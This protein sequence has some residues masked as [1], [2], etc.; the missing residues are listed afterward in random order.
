[1]TSNQQIQS[2][3]KNNQEE[4]NLKKTVYSYTKHWKWFAFSGAICLVAAFFYLRY[5]TPEFNSYAKIMFV[6]D[7]NSS[8][9]AG[10]EVLKDL[11]RFS[12]T[13][14]KKTEDE[15]EAL[16]SRILM[17][18]VVKKLA[19]NIQYSTQ[20]RIHETQLYPNSPIKIIFTA[21]D[22]VVDNSKFSFIINITSNTTFNFKENTKDKESDFKEFAFGKNILTPLGNII[23]TPNTNEV[24]NLI[25]QTITVK[26][27]PVKEVAEYYRNK[28]EIRQVAELSKVVELSLNDAVLER[29]KQ[30]LNTLIDEY[31]RITIEEKNQRAISVA[32]FINERIDL[33]SM[34]L[35]KADDKVEHFKTGNRLTDITS[36]AQLYLNSSSEA[37]QEINSVRSQLSQINYM[38]N[39]VED[40][41]TAFEQIPSNAG[42]SDGSINNITTKYNDLL[43]E[44]NTLLKGST[45]QKNPIIVNLDQQLLGLKQSLVQSLENS[46]KTAS[47]QLS[48]LEA[49]SRSINSKIYAVPGQVRESRDIE[50]EQGIKESL[51]LYLLQKREEATMSLTS[52]SPSV[53]I[54]D[55]AF[56]TGLPVSPKR[57]IVY[58]AAIIIGLCIPFSIIYVSS[59]LDTKIHNKEDL[60]N[61]IKNITVLGEIPSVKDGFNKDGVLLVEKN[62]RSILSESFRIIRTNFDFVRRGRNV[63]HYDNVVFVTSTINGEGKSFFSINTALTMA[64]TGKRVLLMGA[65]IRNPQIHHVLKK[66][67]KAKT[68][69]IG[70]TDFLVDNSILAGETINSY[71]INDIDL[72]IMLSGK[73]PPNPAELLMNSRMKD[74]FDYVSK[75]YDIVIVDTAPAMLVT[76]TLLISQYAGHTIYVTRAGY[77]DKQVLNFAKELHA[78]NK[79]N[80]MMLVVNDVNQSNFGYGA[81]YGYYGAPKKKGFFSRKA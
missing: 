33:I 52:T 72:D 47:F 50:R 23:I 36:E 60:E 21:T 6:E 24:S 74:M 5:A 63:E 65:D 17:E 4:I 54:I 56:S 11:Q 15:I 13:E 46:S 53:R 27:V 64:N 42:L 45:K 70:L 76:D 55:Q 78:T 14:S 32:N 10:V 41:S 18:S 31:N 51:Y 2:N 62:D 1:M 28:M 7:G 12:N 30:I 37:E 9:S 34:D 67:M 75:Q 22:S 80:G 79:L 49:R 48:S 57:N 71:T 8:S 25:D 16:S 38:K 35:S 69:E 40:T 44:R 66:D 19:L 68:S 77:T 26:I 81:R 3:F 43:R 73:I 58:L 39:Y 29:S 20:G 59:I 61:E